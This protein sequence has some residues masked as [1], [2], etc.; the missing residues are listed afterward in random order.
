MPNALATLSISHCT[1]A[2][3]ASPEIG[4]VPAQIMGPRIVVDAEDVAVVIDHT[5]T[6]PLRISGASN[7][8]VSDSI[9]DAGART[10]IAY[11]TR[12][13]PGPVRHSR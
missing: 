1:L 8:T 2:P 10:E 4:G 13:A 11:S 7:V 6:G 5:I 12:I 9:I 3:M